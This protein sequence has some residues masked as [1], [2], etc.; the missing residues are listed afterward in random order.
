LVRK[1]EDKL[2]GLPEEY[3][4]NWKYEN[5]RTRN[6]FLII[7]FNVAHY[8]KFASEVPACTL[9]KCQPVIG[10][11]YTVVCKDCA[12]T[13]IKM[14]YCWE[15]HL[16]KSAAVQTQRPFIAV[17]TITTTHSIHVLWSKPEKY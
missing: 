16:L 6:R 17:Y 4:E 10:I 7:Q 9:S 8:Y 14:A 11:A 12:V 13:S 1:L 3:R 5:L 2:E 15:C